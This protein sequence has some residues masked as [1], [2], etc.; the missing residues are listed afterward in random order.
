MATTDN[1]GE[2]DFNP[3]IADVIAPEIADRSTTLLTTDDAEV[4]P[5]A[6][7]QLSEPESTEIKDKA[8][9]AVP[10]APPLDDEP[11]ATGQ[12]ASCNLGATLD[13]FLCPAGQK[14]PSELTWLD[15]LLW[16]NVPVSA[17]VFVIGNVLYLLL[18][19]YKISLISLISRSLFYPIVASFAFVVF[20]R[21]IKNL[22]Q[23][24]SRVE[25]SNTV[26]MT[27]DSFK[28]YVTA[29]VGL[30]NRCLK[31]YLSVLLCENI[32]A[33]L[34]FALLVHFLG[35]LGTVLSTTNIIYIMFCIMFSIPKL[36]FTYQQQI[37]AFV[38]KARTQLTDLSRAARS[39][40]SQKQPTSSHKKK[41]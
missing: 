18:E 37:D 32:W 10:S 35:W 3:E 4:T 30:L 19:V 5:D 8:K 17:I 1:H 27:E 12:C 41:E 38:H 23:E 13:A 21:A 25:A 7:P 36:Y 11:A 9:Q 26:E 20:R 31:Y 28:P 22:P 14:K 33:T 16:K 6:I 2:S 24:S 40:I 29:L 34:Q 39:K 15:M